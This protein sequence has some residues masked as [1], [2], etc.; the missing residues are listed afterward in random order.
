MK[1]TSII[2]ALLTAAAVFGVARADETPKTTQPQAS[3]P[4]I[5]YGSI[6]DWRAD[7]DRGLWIQDD[8]RRWYYAKLMGP[9]FGLDFA[10]RIGFDTRSPGTFDRFSAII[11]PHEGRCAVQSIVASDPPPRKQKSNGATGT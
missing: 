5:Q 3:I 9:C 6:R 4:F 1:R 2:T 8:R 7:N 11:V 10:T